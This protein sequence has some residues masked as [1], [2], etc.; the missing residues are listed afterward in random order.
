LYK[1]DKWVKL[2]KKVKFPDI[3]K[4]LEGNYE[5]INCEFIGDHLIEA[6]FRPNPD[7]RHGN[8]IA[9]PNWG[10]VD[11]YR[12]YELEQGLEYIEDPDFKRRGFWID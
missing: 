5:W 11:R 9:V 1:W 4:N 12:E 2:D 7:F 6:H 3:L 10:D 8:V